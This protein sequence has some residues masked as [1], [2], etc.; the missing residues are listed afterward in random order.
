MIIIIIAVAIAT[1]EAGTVVERIRTS[2][3][4]EFPDAGFR[5]FSLALRIVQVHPG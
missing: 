3:L 4:F 5:G 2:V 1:T